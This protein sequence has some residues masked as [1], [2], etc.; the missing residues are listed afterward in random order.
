MS[1]ASNL[2]FLHTREAAQ[3]FEYFLLGISLALCAYVGQS[4]KPERLGFS[5]YTIEV[6]SI[7]ILIA[8]IIAGFIR[9]EAMIATSSLNHDVVELQLRRAKLVKREPT[10]DERTGAALTEFQMDFAIS[11]MNKTLLKKQCQMTDA[12][13]RGHKWY[14]WR[15]LLLAVGFAG[16]F[17]AKILDPYFA[18]VA[19]VLGIR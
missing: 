10:F 2:L 5:A 4:T 11:E 16:L 9:V 1:E 7:A 17:L 19:S 13:A 15:K 12:V 18:D 14:W 3:R 8:S 6:L